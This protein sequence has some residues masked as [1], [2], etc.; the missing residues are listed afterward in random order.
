M[1][2]ESVND[3]VEDEDDDVVKLEEDVGAD[4]GRGVLSLSELEMEL[5]AFE[6]GEGDRLE[7]DEVGSKEMDD[8]EDRVLGACAALEGGVEG[9]EVVGSG[10]LD[11]GPLVGLAGGLGLGVSWFG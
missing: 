9:E 2:V 1:K 5:E 4:E 7:A 3:L 11:R 6:V 8:E 10:E